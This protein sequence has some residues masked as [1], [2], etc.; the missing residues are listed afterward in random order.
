MK[1]ITGPSTVSFFKWKINWSMKKGNIITQRSLIL[2]NFRNKVLATRINQEWLA[3]KISGKTSKLTC[4]VLSGAA[5]SI[6]PYKKPILEKTVPYEESIEDTFQLLDK[7]V[8]FCP[9]NKAKYSLKLWIKSKFK[10]KAFVWRLYWLN[11][12][13]IYFF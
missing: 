1:G 2:A 5:Y 3:A 12:P 13:M 9:P 4:P 11:Y 6:E 7:T 10:L 8:Q